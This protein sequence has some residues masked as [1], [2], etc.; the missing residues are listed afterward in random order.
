MFTDLI[1][2][3]NENFSAAEGRENTAI[4]GFS[5]GGRESL[6]IGIT[7]PETFGY[8][9]AVCP[10]PGLVEIK[11]SP[12]HPGQITP[13]EMVFPENESPYVLLISSS[14]ADGVVTDAPDSYRNIL[15]ENGVEYLSHVLSVTGHDHTSVRPH[16]YNF[17]R[18]IFR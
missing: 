2:F 15:T 3:I 6:F 17:F 1:P 10:A 13:E 4:T 9:G 7:H 16:L 18:M 12:M 5:M 11:D 8:I 14:K